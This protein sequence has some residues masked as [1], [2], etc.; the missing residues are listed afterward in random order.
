[1]KVD[2]LVRGRVVSPLKP[3][4]LGQKAEVLRIEDGCVAIVGERIMDVGEWQ[5]LKTLDAP[6][7][8]DFSG[9][10]VT[11]GLIDPHTHALF[12]G[13]R[14]HELLLKL[15][16]LGYKEIAKRGGGIRSTVKATR[17][18]SFEELVHTTLKRVHAFSKSGVTTV[19]IKTG[20]ALN[21]EGE[22]TLLQALK[23]VEK[24]SKVRVL[25]TLLS[26]HAIPEEYEGR[27][28]DY[29]KHVVLKTIDYAC[30]NSLAQFVDVFCEP[31]Y[32]DTQQAKTILE[33][34]LSKGLKAKMHADEFEDS[35]GAKLAAELSLVSADHLESASSEGLSEM[36]R[37]GV[38]AVV[39]PFTFHCS[40]LPPQ[41]ISKYAG[42]CVALGTDYNP[43]CTMDS[44][45]SAMNYAVYEMGM[46]P[47]EA[48]C[49]VTVNAARALA[50]EDVG[51]LK[52]GY[53][54]DLA[55]FDVEDEVE[56]V[57]RGGNSPLLFSMCN[58]RVVCPS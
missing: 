47:I 10:V 17:Q 19:E 3:L 39:L 35:G 41:K 29:V 31:G 57:T 37:R 8:L 20:Y 1:M 58:G 34:A 23:E 25:K 36:A 48:L 44:L 49:A 13:N 30:L 5:T 54:A 55:V 11:P 43:N 50:L 14:S 45:T 56:L 7:V 24:K 16:G 53:R 26:A 18:A 40:M 9:C 51:V 15:Q 52:S 21:V 6:T 32:F 4:T 33:Y 46:Q 12:A 38:C 2:C 28:W 22:I 42:L 27:A